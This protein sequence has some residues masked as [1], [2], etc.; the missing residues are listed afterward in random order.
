MARRETPPFRADHVGSLLRPEALHQARAAF[1]A[2]EID[3]AE[4]AA[5]EDQAITDVVRLQED[6]GLRSATDGEFRREQWHSDFLYAIP[7]IRKGALGSPL[8]VYRKDGQISWTPNATEITGKVH[9]EDVIFGDHFRFL[10]DTVTT[11]TPK[12]TVPSPSM[13]HFRADTTNSPYRDS[14][15][16]GGRPPAP[17]DTTGYDEFRADIAA[18][19]AAEVAGLYALGCRYLQFDDTI[20]AFLNDPGWRANA[21]AT[22]LD[23]EHQHEVNVAVINEALAGKPADMAVTVHMCRGNYRS[24]WFSSGGYDFVAEGVFGGLQVD[25]LF[26]EYDD[27]R[28][29]TFEP[30]RFVPDDQVVVLGLVTTKTPEL[31]SKD[32]LKRR[33]EEAAKYVDID[34]LCLSGQCG[35][36]STVEGNSLTIDSE[37]AKLELIVETAEEIWG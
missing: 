16:P 36:A 6:A 25:G 30:L 32:T 13:A 21:A 20:F 28:S 8:P 22:G 9:L 37:R 4:L 14:A 23:P 5:A 31:E 15:A 2:G 24:A 11:A 10:A 17:P 18:A 12:L 27:E 26:L 34:R 35:F 33:V 29:G 1:A 19:Y 7:G 3:A